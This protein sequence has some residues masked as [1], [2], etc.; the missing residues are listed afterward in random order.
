MTSANDKR[1]IIVTGASRG[2]GKAIALTFGAAGC[3]VI[4]AFREYEQAACMVGDAIRAAG[5]EARIIKMDVRS[6]DDVANM[7]EQTL[8]HWGAIDVLV[9]NAG[10]T[11]DGPLL[12]MSEEQWDQ[13]IDTN[14]TGAFHC[15]RGVSQHMCNRANGHII[16]IASIVGLQGREGQAN[17]SA[18]KAGLIGLTK[19]CA[20]EFGTQNVKV[21]T[22]LPGYLLTDM[23]SAISGSLQDRILRE[24]TLGRST[25]LEEVADFVY[26][27]SLMRNVSGQVFNL[28]SRIV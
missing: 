5:G 13:V 11:Y 1:V 24:H 18:S 20:K 22:V 27:L 23:G 21:N 25:D 4:I 14:L 16:S 15:I 12:R 26:H 19:A 10:L 8:K 2:L 9:N 17:Y 28:D 6:T 7:V 3:C